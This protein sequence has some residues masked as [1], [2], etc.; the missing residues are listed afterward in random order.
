MPG[1][2]CAA[3]LPLARYLGNNTRRHRPRRPQRLDH[4]VARSA[5]AYES[6]AFAIHPITWFDAA[7]HAEVGK[8][9]CLQPA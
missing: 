2:V 3:G 5:G 7:T 4:I 6:G 8:D 9:P 1:L